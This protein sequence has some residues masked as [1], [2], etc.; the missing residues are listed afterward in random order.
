VDPLH[1]LDSIPEPST[2][3]AAT[4]SPQ[5][6]A[7]RKP[8]VVLRDREMYIA[9]LLRDKNVRTMDIAKLMTISERS[10]TRLLAKSRELEYLEYDQSIE[11]EVERLMTDKETILNDEAVLTSTQE[12]APSASHGGGDDS[13]RQ[14][15]INLL[16]MN[17]RPK[18]VA[19]MLEVTE[20]TVNRWKALM[21][22]QELDEDDGNDAKQEG[23]PIFNKLLEAKEECGGGDDQNDV[24]ESF[25]DEEEEEQEY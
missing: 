1:L 4:T 7:E 2:S 8:K 20:K 24:A 3:S 18:D 5:F 6:T 16:S 25:V 13:K 23:H 15:G 17:V 22:K 12:P 21:V 11:D 14:L 10:V 9:R 19:M